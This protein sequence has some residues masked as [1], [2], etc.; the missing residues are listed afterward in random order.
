MAPGIFL[1]PALTMLVGWGLRGFIG[2]GAL[3]AMIPGALV[4]LALCHCL[5]V[6]G[7][8]S[9]RIAAFG[10]IGVGFG[11]QETYGQTVGFVVNGGEMFWRSVVGL[12]VKGAVWGF[13]G[14]AVLGVSF[15]RDLSRRTLFVAL[16]LLVGGTWL[17]WRFVDKP[18][19]IYFSN[20]LDRPREEVWAGLMLGGV[21]FLG[22][23]I[24]ALGGRARIP[25]VFAVLG[26]VG[27]GLGFALGG[28]SFSAGMALGGTVELYPGWKQMEF[29]FGLFFGAA[30]GLAAYWLRDDIAAV[31]RIAIPPQ[32]E[33]GWLM[34]AGV[35]GSVALGAVAIWGGGAALS[36]RFSYTVTGA[37]L[38][39]LVFLS[40]RAA[41]QIAITITAGAFLLYVAKFFNLNHPGFHPA[42]ATTMA[43]ILAA[44]LS[45]GIALRHASGREMPTWALR[46]LLWTSV[47]A[48]VAHAGWHQEITPA[49]I[50][51]VV[52]FVIGAVV[53][54]VRT[55]PRQ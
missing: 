37:A 1:I 20:L 23:M 34:V 29:T 8:V 42:V 51:V 44:A 33:R 17:G 26:L 5:R 31:T 19:L 10:A 52:V 48:G 25:V 28:V 9:G 32:S 15:L 3:G 13:L 40:E 55:R 38:L 47:G 41:W 54:T 11:G 35:I 39:A 2:G 4:A 7:A 36:V 24:Y 6:P 21:G 27:G 50:M 22:W 43:L 53:I 45:A 12:G 49:L 16:L 46:V 18:K 30:L 14:G